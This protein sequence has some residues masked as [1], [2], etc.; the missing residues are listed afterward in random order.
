MKRYLTGFIFMAALVIN[1]LISTRIYAEDISADEIVEKA[2]LM[3]FYQGAD[4]KAKVNMIIT[5]S[6]GRER[7]RTFI[8]L[9][10]DIKDG[11]EQ[12]YY[13]FFKKPADVRNMVFMVWKHIDTDDDRWLYLPALDLVKRIASNDKRTSFAGSHFLY[14]DISGRGINE[15]THELIK[16]T[17]KFYILKN[18]PKDP[19]SVEFDSYN[20]WIDKKTFMPLK[21]EYYQKDEK[22]RTIEALETKKIDGY[23]TVTKSKASDL[24]TGG[25]TVSEFEKVQYDINIDEK[26]FTE[27][28]LRQKPR[29]WLR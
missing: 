27:R 29:K 3:A 22:Y 2:N 4:G 24:R 15:D 23:L 12:K 25:F 8:I 16:Q 1:T 13:V 11:G 18:V 19:Q 9:R 26:I 7:K 6:L 14:E 10:K 5:D 28:Y 21:S 17:D 20:V